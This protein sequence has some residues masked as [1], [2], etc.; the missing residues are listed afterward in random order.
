MADFGRVEV[1]FGF[2]TVDFEFLGVNS[3]PFGVHLKPL[4][5]N[6]RPLSVISGHK[7]VKFRL[8]QLILLHR[9]SILC[10]ILDL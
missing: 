1:Y 2:F 4:E 6:Y 10:V 8:Y 7:G 9:K 3:R 5:V